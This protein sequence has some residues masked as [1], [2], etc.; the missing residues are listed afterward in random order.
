M[1][2]YGGG[3][4]ELRECVRKRVGVRDC[5][6]GRH[7]ERETERETVRQQTDIERER[8]TVRQQTERERERD[9]Q[10]G[11]QADIQRERLSDSRQT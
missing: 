2:V 4:G 1:Y 5:Q 3:G 8:E 11:R 6:T 9:C 7:R 10:T